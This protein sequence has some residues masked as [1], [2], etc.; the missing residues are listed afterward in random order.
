VIIDRAGI[1]VRSFEEG[2]G[3][4]AGLFG[5]TRASETVE[6]SRRKVRVELIETARK[7]KLLESGPEERPRT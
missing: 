3:Q 1:A 5:R 6:N 4:R 7:V 2:I